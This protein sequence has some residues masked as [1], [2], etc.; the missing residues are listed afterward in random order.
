MKK[1]LKFKLL[2]TYS[3]GLI[4]NMRGY[5][6]SE[7]TVTLANPLD[8]AVQISRVAWRVISQCFMSSVKLTNR[9]KLLNSFLVYIFNMYRKHGEN[10]TVKYLKCSL[11]SIQKRVAGSGLKSLRTLEPDLPLPRL[12]RSGLPKIIPWRDRTAILSGNKDI[13]RY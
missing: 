5:I 10:Y 11:L 7:T 1:F 3:F 9:L 6:K 4:N 12:S 8:F 2:K 13:L